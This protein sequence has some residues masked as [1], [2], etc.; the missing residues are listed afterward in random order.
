[1]EVVNNNFFLKKSTPLL[2]CILFWYNFE[3]I[4]D[5]VSNIELLYVREVYINDEFTYVF[6]YQMKNGLYTYIIVPRFIKWFVYILYVLHDWKW[7]VVVWDLV[8]RDFSNVI[9]DISFISPFIT[10]LGTI[11]LIYIYNKYIK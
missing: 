2:V 3:S 4:I 1:M 11:I 7:G 10:M 9:T 5:W 8:I 6:Y